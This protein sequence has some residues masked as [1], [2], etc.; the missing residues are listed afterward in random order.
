MGPNDETRDT[1][2]ADPQT[3]GPVALKHVLHLLLERWGLPAADAALVLGTT[4]ETV[5]RWRQ[6]PARA[7]IDAGLFE[8]LSC[9]VGIHCA[10]TTLIPDEQARDAWFTQP[11]DTTICRGRSPLEVLRD[12]GARVEDLYAIRRYQ[13]GECGG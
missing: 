4:P 5:A 8:R 10:L 1:R 12:S 3:D 13:D 6:V 7:E 2:R 11:N 9:L